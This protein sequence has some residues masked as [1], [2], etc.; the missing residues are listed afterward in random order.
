MV[1]RRTLYILAALAVGC[2]VARL[3]LGSGMSYG[4][5]APA[6]SQAVVSVYGGGLPFP[7][8]LARQK[9]VLL[10][11]DLLKLFPAGVRLQIAGANSRKTVQAEF[12]LRSAATGIVT[13]SVYSDAANGTGATVYETPTVKPPAGEADYV[14][15]G[16]LFAGDLPD[17]F[18]LQSAVL[19]AP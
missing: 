9:I 12:V 13:A 11:V 19:R 1:A 16:S 8:V 2:A 6:G 18:Q 15:E 17:S 10:R 4:P 14:L 3:A 7:V 5:P